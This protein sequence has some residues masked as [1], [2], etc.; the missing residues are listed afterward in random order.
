MTGGGGMFVIS[1][2]GWFMGILILAM[3]MYLFVSHCLPCSIGFGGNGE[4][5]VCSSVTVMGL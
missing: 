5:P 1:G 3:G 4:K 2:R